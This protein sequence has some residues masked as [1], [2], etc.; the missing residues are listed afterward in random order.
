VTLFDTD[1]V[2]EYFRGG[3]TADR[4][5]QILL[6]LE[7]ALSSITVFELFAGVKSEKHLSQREDFIELCEIVELTASV[8][9]RAASLYSELKGQGRLIA[10]EDLFIAA[11][12][13]D[14][15]Y[16]L[17]TKNRAHFERIGGLNLVS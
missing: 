14:T 11:T 13:L 1:V 10:N 8:A 7:A 12:A 15:G 4:A 16:P 9:R 6:R 17:F 5:E 2:F 3:A